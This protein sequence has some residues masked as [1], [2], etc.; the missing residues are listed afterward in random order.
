MAA[1]F[2]TVDGQTHIISNTMSILNAGFHS[3]RS[4]YNKRG[5]TLSYFVNDSGRV[6]ARIGRKKHQPRLFFY[7]S[8]AEA[9]ESF[10]QMNAGRTYQTYKWVA[11][12]EA[13]H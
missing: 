11:E 10:K 3:V 9:N 8:T 7:N 4:Y 2:L 6:I 5:D 1:H 12:K 13:K